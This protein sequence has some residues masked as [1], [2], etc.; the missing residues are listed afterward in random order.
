M[1]RLTSGY[2]LGGLVISV[3]SWL[4]IAAAAESPPLK[5]ISPSHTVALLELYTSEGCN[6][7]PPADKWL[8]SILSQRFQTDQV[9]P[10]A[11]HVDYW[12][13][14]GWPDR[15]AHPAFTSRQRALAA[16]HGSR[17]IYTPQVVLQGKDFRNW[18]ALK[19]QVE[20]INQTK[21]RATITLQVLR[22]RPTT[23]D[24]VAQVHVPEHDN[25]QHAAAYVA[26]YENNLQS[27]VTAGE[28]N[29]QT[30]HHDFVVRQWIGPLSLDA[31]GNVSLQRRFALA[32]DWK[33]PDLGLMAFV[34]NRQNGDVLQAVAL[35]LTN[36]AAAKE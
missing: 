29:G 13:A 3:V 10:L 19:E 15:F 23:L 12:D 27:V 6:S 30:L 4:V 22:D 21:A 26:L 8:Q 32:S 24:V 2:W 11:L 9:I 1:G 31:E 16:W 33:L 25:R 17:T 35:P 20:R 14:L 28:N 36:L 7:C 34:Q 18:R 5:A